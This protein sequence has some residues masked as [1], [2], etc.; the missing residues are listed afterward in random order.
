MSII[1]NV[2]D[3]YFRRVRERLATPLEEDYQN[4]ERLLQ[5]NEG[6]NRQHIRVHR[7]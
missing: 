2:T 3:L 7:S 1:S 5:K 4:L 6:E